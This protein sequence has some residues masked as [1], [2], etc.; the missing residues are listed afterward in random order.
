VQVSSTA[1]MELVTNPATRTFRKERLRS[2][3]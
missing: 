2:Q 3:V 1:L